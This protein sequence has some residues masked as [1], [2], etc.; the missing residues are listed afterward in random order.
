MAFFNVAPTEKIDTL[1]E[2]F[3]R[4]FNTSVREAEAKPT[5]FEGDM[6]GALGSGISS[7]FNR[8]KYNLYDSS[9]EGVSRKKEIAESITK[10]RPDPKT[11]GSAGQLMYGLAEPL[12]F[13]GTEFLQDP[14]ASLLS[15]QT[16]AMNVTKNFE[17]AQTA[18]NIADGMDA[19][20]AA[21]VART[22]SVAMGAGSILPVSVAGKLATRVLTG[23]ALNLAV[24]AGE[25]AETGR[26][27]RSAGYEDMAKQYSALDGNAALAEFILGGVFGGVFGGRPRVRL[28]ADAALPSH[29]DGAL[30]ANQAVNA[31]VDLAPGVPVDGRSAQAHSE[32]LNSAIEQLAFGEKVN[33]EN[34][35][36]EAGFLGKRPDFN[37]VSTIREELAKAGFDDVAAKVRDLETAAQARGLYVEPSDLNVV[38]SDAPADIKVGGARGRE[39]QVKIGNDYV[40]VEYR[41]ME[42]SDVSGTLNKA[43]NQYR[44]RTRVASEQQINEAANNLDPRLLGDSPVMDYGAPVMTADGKVIAGN[45]RAA[46]IERA[47]ETNGGQSYRDYLRDNSEALGLNAAEIDGMQRP[48]LVRVLQRDVDVNKAA[49]LSNEGGAMGMSALEQAK[50]DGERL[51]DFGAFQFGED[52]SVNMAANADFIRSWVREFPTNQISRLMD[53][54]GKLSAEGNRRLQNAIMYRAYGDSD[55][56]ARLIEATDPGSRNIVAALS[57]TAARVADAKEAIARGELYPLDLSEDLLSA[58]EKIDSIKRSGQSVN[59]W[60]NQLD[61]FGDG[62]TGEA[63]ALVVM[64]DRN[65]RSSRAISDAID[66]YYSRLEALGNPEQGSMFEAATPTKQDVFA[67]MLDAGEV[68]YNRDASPLFRNLAQNDEI[69]QYP[70]SDKSDMQAVF[71]DVV[72]GLV[73]SELSIAP[74]GVDEQYKVYPV[75]AG[76]VLRDQEGTINVYPDG[77]VEINVLNW[78][79]GSGGSGVYSAVGNWAL[80]NGKQFAG[81]R[82]GIS[83]AGKMRRLENMISL[84]L[85]FKTTDHIAPHPDQMRELGFDWR[86]GDTNYNIG[87]MMEASYNAIRNGVYVTEN[88]FGVEATYKSPNAVG[89]DKL[90]DLV[91]SF[92]EQRFIDESTGKE[93]TDA[94][95]R[96]LAKTGEARGVA[97]G[98]KTLKRAAL[99]HTFVRQES[100]AGAQRILEQSRMVAYQSLLDTPL[101]GVFYGRGGT[102]S[103]VSDLTATFN[104]QFGKDA[105]RLIEQSRVK[106]VQSVSDLPARSDATPHPGDVGGMY[107]PR[108]GMTYIV[109]DNTA[110]SQVRGRIL[111]EIGVHAGFE[112][113]LGDAMYADV[114]AHVDAKIAAGDERFIKARALAEKNAARPEHVPQETLAYLVENAPESSFGRR[115]L[116]AVR[117]WLYRVTGGRFVDLG[118]NDLV[119]MASASLRRQAFLEASA[120]DGSPM[121]QNAPAM[122]PDERARIAEDFYRNEN[123]G[124]ILSSNDNPLPTTMIPTGDIMEPIGL[125]EAKADANIQSADAMQPGFL[126]AVECALVAG[127]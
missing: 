57:K 50:V 59:E 51:G 68:K 23:G 30:T 92:S 58:V 46:F 37:A 102:R 8:S 53:A 44:D 47:Y 5:M 106:I 54:D 89:V 82:D 39:S 36:T 97:A 103:T 62:M 95:F 10:M 16:L 105:G 35:L 112:T 96:E 118:V 29:I 75:K 121:Y 90:D 22:T 78:K 91:Y 126:S 1:T 98:I 4:G 66:G 17:P 104:A 127:E 33:V 41:V 52:G 73:K 65:I 79:E 77:K 69:F 14:I 6:L 109:A 101:E 122:T 76:K 113:M 9:P 25:R 12:A 21:D 111:H 34:L 15:P 67:P 94:D 81:D 100:G 20:T 84:A 74:D 115:I 87:Q 60:V 40:P 99:A 108:D 110:P 18:V 32:A 43:D 45:G 48:V 24:G 26:I 28:A 114:L 107:D 61:A 7:G 120:R 86:E 56:L 49:I 71:D 116:A 124:A 85:K 31:S 3:D 93:Y 27:L 123:N 117:Q 72:P 13:I 83:A 19:N 63:R 42:S 2:T 88:R 80:N 125:A 55:T 11:L 119:E 70:R 64:M 38:L